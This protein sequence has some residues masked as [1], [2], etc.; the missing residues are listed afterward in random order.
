M[1]CHYA[2]SGVSSARFA[3]PSFPPR[4]RSL[5]LPMSTSPHA[6]IESS[7]G[8]FHQWF[9]RINANINRTARSIKRWSAVC[10]DT[11][12]LTIVKVQFEF[13]VYWHAAAVVVRSV[14][15]WTSSTY[16]TLQ[17]FRLKLSRKLFSRHT[18]FAFC[19]AL[20]T[21]FRSGVCRTIAGL[22]RYPDS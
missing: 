5:F 1:W 20:R 8:D 4:P 3:H 12:L 16:L 17:F 2:S 6:M 18:F 9:F 15:V 11:I 7:A 14:P 21:F 19:S 13:T 10:I 22:A